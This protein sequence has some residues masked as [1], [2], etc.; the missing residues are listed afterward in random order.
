MKKPIADIAVCIGT[1]GDHQRWSQMVQSRALP[2]V[3]RQTMAPADIVWVHAPTLREARNNAAEDTDAEW[4][5][6]LDADDELDPRYIEVMSH[7][8]T[9]LDG[10]WLLQPATRGVYPDGRED[11]QSVV[12]PARPLLEG[13]YMVIGTLVRAS[14]FQR[15]GGFA[16]WPYAEDWDLW[17]RCWRDGAKMRAVPDAIYRVLVNGTGRNSCDRALQIRTYNAIRDQY[18]RHP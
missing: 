3:E 4:L 16:N 1:Y 18:L 14:Q 7:V 13:N 2:S 9:H 11:P 5:C 10:D 8:S 6:F 17:I 15:L 12:I